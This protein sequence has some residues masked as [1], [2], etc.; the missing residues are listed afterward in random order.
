MRIAK[1]KEQNSA[2][3][4]DLID[5]ESW[6]DFEKLSLKIIEEFSGDIIEQ[7]DG[8]EGSRRWIIEFGNR[9]LRFEYVDMLC[10]TIKSK[11]ENSEKL[12]QDIIHYLKKL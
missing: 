3:I 4:I 1:R 2:F 10:M 11:Y 9:Q 7:F 5:V 12:I 6:D 8:P